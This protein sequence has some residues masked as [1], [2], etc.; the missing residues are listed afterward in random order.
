MSLKEREEEK[1][2]EITSNSMRRGLF[3]Y[4]VEHCQCRQS[5]VIENEIPELDYKNA[6]LIYF[7]KKENNGRYGLINGYRDWGEFALDKELAIRYH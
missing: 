4:M 1:G 6:N 7:T 2:T 5:I 3:R